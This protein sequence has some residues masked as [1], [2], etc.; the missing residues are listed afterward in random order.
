[1]T[2][3]EFL[4]PRQ[5]FFSNA[6]YIVRAEVE[7]VQGLAEGNTWSGMADTITDGIKCIINEEQEKNE[8]NFKFIKNKVR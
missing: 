6:K 5:R 7:K 3:N 4:M 2:E 1:M 8:G